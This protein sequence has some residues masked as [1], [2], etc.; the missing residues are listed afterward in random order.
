MRSGLCT[1]PRRRFRTVVVLASRDTYELSAYPGVRPSLTDAGSY[2]LANRARFLAVKLLVCV[3]L[4]VGAGN[5]NATD[6]PTSADEISTDRP[7]F[8]SP[9]TVVLTENLI[10][11]DGAA[12]IV[13]VQREWRRFCQGCCRNSVHSSREQHGWKR[14]ISSFACNSSF[15]AES[16]LAACVCGI[17][18][19]LM[20]VLLYRM[21]PA[22]LDAILIVQLETLLRW[23]LRFPGLRALAF[24]QSRWPS[25]N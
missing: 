5:A 4:F 15:C 25:Q 6:C 23:H 10:R 24:T 7:D 12:R 18:N 22:L 20:L 16:I 9:P 17:S 1:R 21:F 19:R 3:A 13:L 8:T 2:S 14:K 11:G